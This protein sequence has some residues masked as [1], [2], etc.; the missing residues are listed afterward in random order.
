[1]PLGP[2]LA[3]IAFVGLLA[4]LMGTGHRKS[5]FTC[6]P[7]A[8]LHG[9]AEHGLAAISLRLDYAL[10]R[11]PASRYSHRLGD[12]LLHGKQPDNEC[13]E[14]DGVLQTWSAVSAQAC[15]N[16]TTVTDWCALFSRRKC[17]GCGSLACVHWLHGLPSCCTRAVAGTVCTLGTLGRCNCLDSE[18]VTPYAF[19]R[20]HFGSSATSAPCLAVSGSLQP[21]LAL[22]E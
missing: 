2:S 4:S 5:C 22:G 18:V 8:L 7:R 9:L 17:C 10:N 15:P 14:F 12:G 20:S 11:I 3:G 19:A 6:R 1:M 16:A 13:F 21:N